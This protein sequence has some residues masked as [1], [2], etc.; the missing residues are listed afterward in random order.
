[1][2]ELGGTLVTPEH[3]YLVL[4]WGD[5]ELEEEFF[6]EEITMETAS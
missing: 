4:W 1:M 3:V 6:V 2:R 5:D